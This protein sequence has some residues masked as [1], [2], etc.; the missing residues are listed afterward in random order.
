MVNTSWQKFKKKKKISSLTI[1]ALAS[2]NILVRED[3]KTNQKVEGGRKDNGPIPAEIRIGDERPEEWK[4]RRHSGPRVHRGSRRRC[5][6]A[7][8][9]RQV[10]DQVGGDAGVRRPLRYLQPCMRPPN[11]RSVI[12]SNQLL[13]IDYT[14]KSREKSKR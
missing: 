9:P 10:G 3:L 14:R 1:K 2:T 5:R 13:V 12:S 7:E 6:L 4:H 11:V 8:G